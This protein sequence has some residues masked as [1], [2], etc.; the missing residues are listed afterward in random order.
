MRK[1]SNA[2]TKPFIFQAVII[3]IARKHEVLTTQSP[4]QSAKTI[5][6]GSLS[7]TTTT[8]NIFQVAYHHSCIVVNRI[9]Y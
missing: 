3:V 4:P 9:G 8:Q 5:Y 1:K 7:G 2:N 6:L